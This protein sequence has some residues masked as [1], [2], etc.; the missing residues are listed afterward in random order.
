MIPVPVKREPC[1][2]T[3]S[4]ALPESMKE[5]VKLYAKANNVKESEAV[6]F[7]LTLFFDGNF[8]KSKENVEKMQGD[9]SAELEKVTA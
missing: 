6:R 4:V 5:R 1:N 8:E 2:R 7:I 9:T 3:I